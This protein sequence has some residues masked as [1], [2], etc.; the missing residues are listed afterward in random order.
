[1]PDVSDLSLLQALR[2]AGPYC[3]SCVVLGR[4][5]NY[6]D[7]AMP[8]GQC[9]GVRVSDDRDEKT[10]GRGGQPRVSRELKDRLHDNGV[11]FSTLARRSTAFATWLQIV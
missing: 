10:L 2:F 5:A 9:A 3:W 1:M 7:Q 8:I 11:T 4:V 6:G